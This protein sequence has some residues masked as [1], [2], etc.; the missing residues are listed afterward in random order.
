MR[1]PSRVCARWLFVFALV[2]IGCGL[3]GAAW[4]QAAEA[5]AAASKVAENFLSRGDYGA[6]VV[7]LGLV[8]VALSAVIAFL[9]R[10]LDKQSS[11]ITL[12][13]GEVAKA[14]QANTAATIAGTLATDSLR[15]NQ[16]MAARAFEGLSRQVEVSQMEARGRG[17]SI[18]KNQETV[19]RRLED[20]RP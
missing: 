8:I 4:A 17:E 2:A 9:F 3:A 11:A 6:I 13:V 18:L 12:M 14:L 15:A 1:W 7:A 20:R 5:A 16:D 10:K 19:L